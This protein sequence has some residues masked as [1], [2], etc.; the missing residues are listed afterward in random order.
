MNERMT[1]Q[2][3]IECLHNVAVVGCSGRMV[4]GV[5]LDEF[6][7]HLERFE[8]L[9]ILVLDLTEVEQIDAAGL[10]TMLL[11]RQWAAQRSVLIKL[12]NPTPFVRRVLEATHLAS[13]FEIASLEEALCILRAPLMR[14]HYFAA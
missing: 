8:G 10:S 2:Y 13:V 3:Q 7:T 11:L 12:V 4:R 6:R 14:A 1:L 5:A 9:R